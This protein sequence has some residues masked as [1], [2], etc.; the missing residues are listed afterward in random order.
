MLAWDEIQKRRRQQAAEMQQGLATSSA[1]VLAGL[2]AIDERMR[3][4]EER[5]LQREK[6]RAA[7]E[8]AASAEQRAVAREGRESEALARSTATEE[9][10]EAEEAARTT[11]EQARGAAV[12][13]LARSVRQLPESDDMM[14]AYR[15]RRDML[16]RA[17]EMG[18]IARPEDLVAQVDEMNAFLRE[19]EQL[20]EQQRKAAAAA[21]EDVRRRE[22]KG[23]SLEE[24]RIQVA[25][26][27][28][29]ARADAAAARAE[30]PKPIGEAAL[31]EIAADRAALQSL[32]DVSSIAA[33][34]GIST[35]KIDN[36]LMEI[37]RKFGTDSP[38]AAEFKSGVGAF[39]ADYIKS[40]SGATVGDKEREMLLQVVP[41][42]DDNDAAF[43]AKLGRVKRAVEQKLNVRLDTLRRGGRNVSGFSDLETPAAPSAA[44]QASSSA[45]ATMESLMAAN[46]Q[47]AGESDED[48]QRRIITLATSAP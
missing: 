26:E 37:S 40:I 45:E 7:E 42:P 48:Y 32:N 36:A 9:R 25:R 1:D 10:R 3:A 2:S 47:R 22:W 31:G 39:V 17:R 34:Y 28:A 5:R 15:A 20:A 41:T 12:E 44:P 8:R 27:A 6:A 11:K 23:L 19:K 33:R 14:A 38:E 24:E 46:P 18:D 4:D 21:A 30:E 13:D 16:A 43:A 35:G 29:G